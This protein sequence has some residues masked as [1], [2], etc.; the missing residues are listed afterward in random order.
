MSPYGGRIV[1]VRAPDREGVLADI[2][3]GYD[4]AAA[5]ERDDAFLGALV[6]RYANRIA[7]GRFALDGRTYELPVNNPPN[8]LHG[9]PGGFHAVPWAATRFDEGA[10]R[11]LLLRRMSVA[12]EEGYP[13]TV[14][15]RVTLR[16]TADDELVLDYRATTDAATPINLTQH[17][18]WNLAGHDAGDI[19]D[20][21]LRIA[22]SRYLPVDATLIPTGELRPVEGTAF[23]F[24]SPARIGARI[25]DDDPQ[26]RHGRGYDHTWVLDGAPDGARD[27]PDRAPGRAPGAAPDTPAQAARLFH[28]P[29]GRFL[30]VLTTEPGI[31]VYTGN[32]LDG[33]EGKGGARYGPRA[34][35]ALETQHF[36]DS[37]NQAAFP[38][39]ILR[40]GEEY[41]SRTVYRFGVAAA[42]RDRVP[43]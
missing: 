4:N 7:G 16:L 31:Q 8:H 25:D 40:P 1:A 18:Y 33:L 35:I 39:T 12:G 13:G 20:H 34:G 28:P 19:L 17:S 41:R 37:P 21:E 43:A 9:G 24:Q 26:L 23:D 14:D 6:G 27:A 29:T 5:Y 30:E 32:W 11:G 15:V 38:S 42:G 22:A 2:T 36:P 3:L 10:T